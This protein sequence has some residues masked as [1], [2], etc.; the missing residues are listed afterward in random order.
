MKQP[1]KSL[2][3]IGPLLVFFVV[4]KLAGIVY[5]TGA[6]LVAT[7]LAVSVTYVMLKKVPLMP[8]ISA[9]VVGFFGGLTIISGDE[10]FIKIKPTLINLIFAAILIVGAIRGKGLL[11]NVMDGA[12]QMSEE[13][14]VKLSVRWAVFFI[15][16]AVSNEF[17]WRN[18]PTDIWVQFK[19]FGLL[20]ATAVFMLTQMPFIKKNMIE[21]EKNE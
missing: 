7:L 21:E 14:W 13:A 5:A 2:V 9:L 3:D 16:L 15:I 20:S 12:L 11:K 6:L 17:V 1:L 4:F 18:Y 8:L 19:V 10:T